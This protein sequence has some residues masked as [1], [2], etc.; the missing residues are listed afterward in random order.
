MYQYQYKDT[1]IMYAKRRI[2]VHHI[3]E[4]DKPTTAFNF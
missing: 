3:S 4:T 2:Y 1:E